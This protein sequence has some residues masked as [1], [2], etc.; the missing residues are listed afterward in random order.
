MPVTATQTGGLLDTWGGKFTDFID[1]TGP[2][3]YATGGETINATDF[4]CPNNLLFAVGSASVSGTY[5]TVA[6]PVAAGGYTTWKL[7]WY[8]S[9]T[10][11]EAGAIDLSAEKAKVFGVGV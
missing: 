8:V 11:A 7:M 3:L 4:G 6:R 1:W 5:F 9:A 2:V 10:G